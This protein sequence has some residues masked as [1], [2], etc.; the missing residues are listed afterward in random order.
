[1]K[2]L[3]LL[4]GDK[5]PSSATLREALAKTEAEGTA[6]ATRLQELT[7]ARAAALLGGDDKQLDA[8]EAQLTQTTRHAD[9]LDLAGAELRR[10]LDQAVADERQA[11]LDEVYTRAEDARKRAVGIVKGA[12]RKHALGVRQAVHELYE[13]HREIGAAN[14]KLMVAN[15]SKTVLPIDREAR[16]WPDGTPSND[17][18]PIWVTLKLPSSEHPSRLL[19]PATDVYGIRLHEQD[20]PKR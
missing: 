11:E 6:T 3:D 5:A 14:E 9:R 1:M 15:Y 2:I 12:Y 19:W 17:E 10:R 18:F 20:W 7:Q 13:L 4:K 8:I 16:P